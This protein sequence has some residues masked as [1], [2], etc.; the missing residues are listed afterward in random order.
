[1]SSSNLEDISSNT[2]VAKK[3]E[4]LWKDSTTR[5]TDILIERNPGLIEAAVKL[6]QS[7]Q[8]PPNTYLLDMDNHRR[9]ARAI[10]REARKFGISLY[11]M[12][13]QAGR[14]PIISK[15]V[16]DEGFNGLVT[17]EAQEAKSLYR[18]GLKIGHV[19]HLA[20]IPVHEIDYLLSMSPEVWTVYSYENARLVSERA[21]KSGRKQKLLIQV[22]GKDDFFMPTSTGGIPEE[23]LSD[24]IRKISRLE[25]TKI[26]GTT[27]FPCLAYDVVLQTVKPLPNFFTAVRAAALMKDKFGLDITQINVP[28]NNHVSSMKTVAENGGTHAEP[29]TAVS[30]AYAWQALE[31][32]VEIPAVVYVSEI[33]HR[34][35]NRVFVYGGGTAFSGGSFLSAPSSKPWVGG[36]GNTMD[37]IIKSPKSSKSIKRAKLNSPGRDP[38]NYNLTMLAEDNDDF[39]LGD[40]VLVPFEPQIFVTRAWHAVVGGIER[41]EPYLVGLFDQGNNLIDKHGHLQGERAVL[42]LLNKI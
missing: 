24:N 10:S 11:Y 25:G 6:H 28:M 3:P 9:N 15:A 5:Y 18:Y 8:I 40:T 36:V 34:L 26:V 37:A 29:G 12:S 33:S 1:M 21:E 27:S 13:K 23:D 31:D 16:L 41:N 2:E 4:D 38:F 14:N 42:E 7:G 20:Q 17:V 19:G 32:K 30:G 35:G 39:S 22:M